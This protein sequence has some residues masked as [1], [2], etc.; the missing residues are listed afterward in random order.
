MQELYGRCL[1]LTGYDQRCRACHAARLRR[2]ATA[3][4]SIASAA[5]LVAGRGGERRQIQPSRL[6][7]YPRLQAA[8]APEA[9]TWAPREETWDEHREEQYNELLNS[10]KAAD[11]NHNGRI[12]RDEL[13]ALLERVNTGT[14]ETIHGWWSDEDVEKVM[15]QYDT[16]KSGDIDFQEFEVLAR[17]KVLL[18]GKLEEY[19]QAFKAVDIGGNGKIGA[20]ELAELFQ[21]LGHPLT[22]ERLVDIMKQYD[23]DHS[24]QIEFGEFLRMFQKDLLDLREILDY[25]RADPHEKQAPTEQLQRFPGEVNLLFSEQ[26]LDDIIKEEA[27]SLV[28]LMS[29]VTWCRPCKGMQKAIQNL[30]EHYKNGVHMLRLYG[31]SNDEC[32]HLF[33][34]RLLT[35]VTPTFFF[36]RNGE[37]V[38]THTG[39]NKAKL[40]HYMRQFLPA[41]SNMPEYLY[42]VEQQPTGGFK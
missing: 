7:L 19:E 30:A 4:R 2:T 5:L 9:P 31:N 6:G 27:S 26:E 29:T 28:V 3:R 11:T 37:I 38:H 35:R 42:P 36:W 16:D 18:K 22:Y 39:A 12:D 17:D 8:A 41:S 24:G 25:I 1:T 14:T 32:K 20:S 23:V 34:D 10:F 15:Q 13:K 40:E 21:N 33:K